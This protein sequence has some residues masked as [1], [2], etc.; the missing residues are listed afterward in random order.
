MK[1]GIQFVKERISES[2]YSEYYPSLFLCK[3]L[4]GMALRLFAYLPCKRW[5]NYSEDKSPTK[6]AIWGPPMKNFN[7]VTLLG[8][9]AFNKFHP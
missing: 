8:N 3:V 1:A 2:Q 5:E 9:L 6:P 7:P 4:E